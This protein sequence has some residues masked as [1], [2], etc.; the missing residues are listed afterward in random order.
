[1]PETCTNVQV[2]GIFTAKPGNVQAYA[3]SSSALFCPDLPIQAEDDKN[4][5]GKIT[6]LSS[7]FDR[8]GLLKSLHLE[9][10]LWIY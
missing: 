9:D 1:M 5:T 2:S 10:S 6:G 8:M 3:M 7:G 4:V